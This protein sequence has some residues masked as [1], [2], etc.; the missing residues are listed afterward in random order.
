MVWILVDKSWIFP[1][2]FPSVCWL[3]PC[4]K[5][6]FNLTALIGSPTFFG[7][8]ANKSGTVHLHPRSVGIMVESSI[9]YAI[10]FLQ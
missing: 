8:V 3:L 4:R 10:F 5:G 1:L 6:I 7:A 9:Y 2:L